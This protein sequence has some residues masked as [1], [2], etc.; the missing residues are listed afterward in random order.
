MT[1]VVIVNIVIAI[2]VILDL[3]LFPHVDIMTS[4]V[5]RL[6]QQELGTAWSTWVNTNDQT[7]WL[8]DLNKYLV[9]A[10]K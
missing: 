8:M 2:V 4:L 6:H 5:S 7:K 9:M 1:A 10:W 3:G